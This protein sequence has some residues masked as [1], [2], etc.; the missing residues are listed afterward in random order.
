[1]LCDAESGIAG[2]G[3]QVRG[4]Q[5]GFTNQNELVK[6]TTSGEWGADQNGLQ[7]EEGH[8]RFMGI[9]TNKKNGRASA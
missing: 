6:M 9:L 7:N 5:E 1:M 4:S 8:S 3:T 2:L